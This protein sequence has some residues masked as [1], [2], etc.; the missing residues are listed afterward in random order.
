MPKRSLQCPPEKKL[1]PNQSTLNSIKT[2][3]TLTE[4]NL[5][6]NT[7]VVDQ[8]LSETQT[9]G[10][11][12][13]MIDKPQIKVK[14]LD[15][16]VKSENDKKEYRVIELENGL[17]A[18]LIADLH[19]SSSQNNNS[20]KA[21]S[22]TSANESEN[23]VDSEQASSSEDES[24]S[25]N[26]DNEECDCDTEAPG[27]LSTSSKQM[28]RDEKMAACGLSISV[29][30][31]SDPPEIPG[32]AHFLEHMVFMGS[33]KY[34]QEN[35]FDTFIKKRGGSDNACTDCELTTYYFEVQEK[36][37]LAAL[38]RFAQFF[39]SP[40]MK[41]DAIT[42]EREAVESEFQ[43]A[44]PSDE[45][46]KEQ[47]FSSFAKQDHPAKK[48]GWGNLVTLRDNV[49][50]EKLY[51]QLHKFRERHYSAH[52]MKVA[53]QAKLPLDVLEDYVKQC[54]AKVTNNGLPVDD[55]SMFKGVESFHTPSFRRIYKIKPIKD[56]RQVELTWSMP[57]V[58][59]LYKSKPHEY[60]SWV[61][62]NKGK[63][64]LISYL[65]KKM[66]CLD[67]DID[68]ADSG[69]TDSSMYALFTISL[70]LTEQGQEQLQEVLNAIFSFINLMQK[71]GPQKQ[72]FDEMQ[73]I[74]EMNFRFMDETPPAEYV[75]D[76]CQ[77]MH[78]YP[79]SDY[80]TG[81]E[82]Y[83]EYNPKAIQEYMNCLTPDN[84]N[85]MILD[86][87]FNDEEFDK[88][89]PWFK[90][91]YTD[92][93]I[94]QE[95]VDCWK[96]IKPLPEFHLPLPNVFL[97]DDFSLI[98]IPSDVS[99]YPTKIHSD[100]ILEV[101]YRP[102]PKFCLPECY[103]YFNIVTPLVLSSPKSAALMDLFVATLKQLL[104]EQLYPAE[105]AKL[106]YDIYTN[107]KGIL[108]AI[109]GFNQKLPLLLMIIAKY[110]ANSPNLVSEEL[111]EVIKEKTTRE[112]YNTFLKP[113][114]LV[115]DVRLSILMLVHWPAL[116]KHI[117]IK[118][119]QFHE[120]QN[121]VR[122]FTDH[123]YIQSLVQGNMTK[124]DVIKNVKEF[125][126]TLKCG[127]LLPHTMP[128]IRVAQIPTGTYCCKVKN[129]N[130]T[131][132]NSVVMNYYQSGVTSIRLSVIIE[133]I[134]MIMEEPLFNQLRT[135]EQLGYH[136][137][138]ILRDTFNILGYS[139]TV[140]T[141]ANKYTTEHVDN[142]IEAFVQM[143][144]GILKEMSEKE[145]E[146]IKEALMKLKL[147]DDVHLK[148]EVDRNWV[149]ITTG[150]Y[151]FDKIEKELLMIE[152]ITLDDLREWMDSHTLNGNNLRKLSVHVVGTSDP[153]ES[154]DDDL[155]PNEQNSDQ[156]QEK[157]ATT[158]YPLVYLPITDEIE[159]KSTLQS[160]TDIQEYKSR[161]YLYPT[162]HTAL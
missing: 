136:V 140:H 115:K 149:E 139:I 41:K 78:Y 48:F 68:N 110:I 151:M 154:N 4:P 55:F 2:V 67:I 6:V 80:L 62:G 54:F 107:D 97:T 45:N 162:K 123:L 134:I 34:P 129:F 11:A 133:L 148:E 8:L 102:D 112:Y 113:K 98:S 61:L 24:E 26:T 96:T 28:K 59:H 90:T 109:N 60:I 7:M 128:Q 20:E 23:E 73:Q 127:P 57:P 40:L 44:L 94:P 79:P 51:D 105:V 138:C 43:M 52:R 135:L 3:T 38:D 47:L 93:E 156:H 106:N 74:K 30:S 37:L 141:Q 56:V 72:L 70:I 108:L 158:K 85:I 49:S 83:F 132:V 114:K 157:V 63:G 147:C 89:E 150:N 159:N 13:T 75:E 155:H 111:F 50:E 125:V 92:T 66:W 25:D 142:R 10:V 19:V 17:T 121:F 39:I 9:E 88:V 119:I 95:W 46:R 144:K 27:D 100:D 120:F 124:E 87:K 104:V 21:H 33:E 118:N 131:D 53:I 65:R 81:S 99:K 36:H 143:F 82:L 69:F 42:R 77:D 103:M 101:W 137:F 16:P 71:E 84:V 153:K 146:S 86:K 117:A 64:S 5:Q 22:V 14:Y 145:L 122:Y 32:L 76:L 116:D 1:K 29:G 126:E 161:L 91:K 160:V 12:G 15:T 58:Q 35:D 18:L 152:Q 130:K 31:F